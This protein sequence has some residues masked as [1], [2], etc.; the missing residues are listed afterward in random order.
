MNKKKMTEKQTCLLKKFEDLRQKFKTAFKSGQTALC[1]KL[2]AELGAIAS[3][4]RSMGIQCG[5]FATLSKNDKEYVANTVDFVSRNLTDADSDMF[6]QD[7][8]RINHCEGCGNCNRILNVSMF[9][10]YQLPATATVEKTAPE[11]KQEQ[12]LQPNVLPLRN[13]DVQR[14][15]SRPKTKAETE[16]T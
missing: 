2:R 11:P 6:L 3:E 15:L 14:G 12:P 5:G 16:P 1:A 8:H 10:V 4:L 13:V 9:G 7:A